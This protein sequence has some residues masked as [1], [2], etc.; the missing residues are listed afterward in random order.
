MSKVTVAPITATAKGLV[1]EVPLGQA[2]GL[3]QACV[4]SLDNILTIDQAKLGRSVGVLLDAQEPDLARA[5]AD[6]FDLDLRA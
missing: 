4:A 1:S 5:L 3:D 2:N 6:T